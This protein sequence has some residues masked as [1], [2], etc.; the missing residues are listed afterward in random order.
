MPVPRTNLEPSL[1]NLYD[2]LDSVGEVVSSTVASGSAVA[3]TTATAANVTSIT[4]TPGDWNVFGVVGFLPAAT[5]SITAVNG[6]ASQV[7]A[8]I[9]PLGAAFTFTQAAVVPGAVVQEYPIPMS[10]VNVPANT[11]VTVYLVARASF[12]V[13]TLG[14]YGVISARRVS[15]P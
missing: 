10:R 9:A 1:Q 14:A 4:L 2:Y 5:T 15:K 13:S 11:T 6:G 7:S 12:T 8:T 3:L